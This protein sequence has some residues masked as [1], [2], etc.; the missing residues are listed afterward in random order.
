M[1]KITLR[2]EPGFRDLL[3]IAEHL[4]ERDREEL[5]A[6]RYGNNVEDLARDATMA[7]AMRWAAY[8]DEEPVAA[9]GAVPRWPGVWT[10]WAYGTDRF[11][12]AILTITRHIRRFMLPA[13]YN[14]GVHRVDALA[15]AAH[16]DARRW[17]ESLGAEQEFLLDKYGRS[18]ETFVSYVWTREKTK[19][20]I[21]DAASV[22]L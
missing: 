6:T 18:G 9:F 8:A 5:F 4:R 21:G 13:L 12:E 2:A 10:A 15:L 7:G 11:P 16:T 22:A 17:L 1:S 20:L 19:R 3:F 14:S